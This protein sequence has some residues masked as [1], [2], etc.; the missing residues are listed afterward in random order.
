MEIALTI[1]M[2]RAWSSGLLE[3]LSVS[4]AHTLRLVLTNQT[5]CSCLLLTHG[6][7]EST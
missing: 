1:W 4:Q 2:T 7:K 5:T 3:E 6:T